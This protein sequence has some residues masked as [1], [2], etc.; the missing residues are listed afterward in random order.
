MSLRAYLTPKPVYKSAI[1]NITVFFLSFKSLT[2]FLKKKI[3]LSNILQKVLSVLKACFI[4]KRDNQSLK[5]LF[6]EMI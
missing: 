6:S 2:Y 3:K 1:K 5:Y 4:Y